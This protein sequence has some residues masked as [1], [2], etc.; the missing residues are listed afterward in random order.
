[1]QNKRAIAYVRVSSDE[2]V[3]GYSLEHQEAVIRKWCEMKGIEIAAV[4]RESYSAKNFTDRP[5]YKELL[6]YAKKFK[7]LIDYMLVLKW[8]R[9]SRNAPDAYQELKTFRKLGIEVQAIEQ[10]LDFNVPENKIMLSIYLSTPEVENDRRSMNTR[11][12]LRRGRRNGRWMGVAPRGY[13]N[14]RDERNKPII[15]PDKEA[16]LIRYAF[17]QFATG[18]YDKEELRKIMLKKGL[19]YG[20]SQFPKMLEN[21]VYAGKVLVKEFGDEEEEIRDGLHEPI[22]SE[23][24]FYKVQRVLKAKAANH[25]KHYETLNPETPLRN[26]LTCRQC[27]NKLTSSKS[28]GR[29]KYYH[30]YHCHN[31]CK[32]RINAIHAHEALSNYFDSVKVSKEVQALYMAVME[33]IFKSN[34]SDTKKELN[35]LKQELKSAEER[36]DNLEEKYIMGD[37]EKDS[38]QRMKPKFK[39]TIDEINF[40]LHEVEGA[41]TNHMKY[42]KSSFNLLQNLNLYYEH[43]PVED[44]QKI[45]GSIF[46]EKIIYEN[47]Q[48]R[49]AQENPVIV[50]LRGFKRD[51]KKKRVAKK[52]TLPVEYPGPESNRHDREVIGV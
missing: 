10:P 30:Y 22:V 40:K 34:G 4:F 32:E 2:Q 39:E 44:K 47:E 29:S 13:K 33:D 49:T 46:P 31:G 11:N 6:K 14:A 5:E 28:K 50:A 1:M 36:L 20:K 17:E 51:F 52:A 18:I 15:I 19:R 12:G 38:Y 21:V 9:F 23:Q 25:K 48:C 16:D 3:K 42:V 41:D 37:I 24:L 45:I 26:L 35:K 43:A 27:G 8:D 7:K